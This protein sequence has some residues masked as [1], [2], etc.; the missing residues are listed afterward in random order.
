MKRIL[1]LT[2]II[3]QTNKVVRSALDGKKIIWVVP[4][5]EAQINKLKV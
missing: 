4:M 5:Q 2:Q 3:R 1:L